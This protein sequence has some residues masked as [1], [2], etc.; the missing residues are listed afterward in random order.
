MQKQLLLKN[1]IA[2]TLS[3]YHI[4]QTDQYHTSQTD[5]N[6]S[7]HLYQSDYTNSFQMSIL[8]LKNIIAL[9]LST[10]HISQTNRNLSTHLHQPVYTNQ[11][12]K[13]KSFWKAIYPLLY[14]PITSARPISTYQK[15]FISQTIPIPSRRKKLLLISNEALTLSTYHISQTNKNL[16]I[17]LHHPD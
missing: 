14:L 4:S 3:T 7:T 16:L 12:Q 13:K 15:I 2:L 6:L 17:H 9:T 1:N 8:F 10:Y 11:F 5:Q